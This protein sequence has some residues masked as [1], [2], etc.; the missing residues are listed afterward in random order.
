MMHNLF[1]EYYFCFERC[2]LDVSWKWTSVLYDWVIPGYK[3]THRWTMMN[4]CTNPGHMVRRFT[5]PMF[6]GTLQ[7][8]HCAGND[9]QGCKEWWF[10]IRSKFD[11]LVGVLVLASYQNEWFFSCRYM[12]VHVYILYLHHVLMS[13]FSTSGLYRELLKRSSNLSRHR[14]VSPKD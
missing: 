4:Y 10:S 12:W 13:L 8:Q 6:Q 11:Q 1:G 3:P 14:Q 2:L 9:G 5:N 7:L